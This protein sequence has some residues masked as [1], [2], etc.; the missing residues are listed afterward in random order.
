MGRKSKLLLFA[1]LVLAFLAV[2]K[3]AVRAATFTDGIVLVTSSPFDSGWPA[4]HVVVPGVGTGDYEATATVRVWRD[5]ESWAA[6]TGSGPRGV[7]VG[8]ACKANPRCAGKSVNEWYGGTSFAADPYDFQTKSFRFT[9][10]TAATGEQH[11]YGFMFSVNDGAEAELTS[12][13]LKKK[14]S[15]G[16]YTQSIAV[17]NFN[18][19]SYAA[20]GVAKEI[21]TRWSSPWGWWGRGWVAN[22]NHGTAGDKQAT[23]V[24]VFRSSSR[25][26]TGYDRFHSEGITLTPGKR[27]ILKSRMWPYMVYGD[28]VD[29]NKVQVALA[30]AATTCGKRAD[31]TNI[32][33]NDWMGSINVTARTSGFT[34]FVSTAIQIPATATA[35]TWDV[36]IF[37]NDGSQVYF[38]SLLLYEEG[39]PTPLLNSDPYFDQ[40]QPQTVNTNF[41]TDWAVSQYYG[42]AGETVAPWPRPL[43]W[44]LNSRIV[45][46]TGRSLAKNVHVFHA[47]WPPN[48]LTWAYDTGSRTTFTAATTRAV[49]I[50]S[51]DGSNNVYLGVEA[52]HT[53]TKDLWPSGTTQAYAELKPKGN[54]PHAAM[55]FARYFNPYTYMVQWTRSL[56]QGTYTVDFEPQPEHM[57]IIC[58]APSPTPTKTP[59]PTPTKTPTP[60]LVPTAACGLKTKGD[61]NCDNLINEADYTIWKCQFKGGTSCGQPNNAA[62]FDL[63]G[64][65]TVNDFEIWRRFSSTVNVTPTNSPTPTRTPT[66][67]P[68]KTPTPTPTAAPGTSYYKVFLTSATYTGALGGLTGADQKCQTLANNAGLTGTY[69]AWLTDNNNNAKDRIQPAAAKPYRLVDGTTVIA[70]SLA[71]LI[72]GTIANPI[73]KTEAGTVVSRTVPYVWTGT[74]PGGTKTVD[75]QGSTANC[76]NWTIGTNAVNGGIGDFSKTTRNWTDPPVWTVCNSQYSLYCFQTADTRPGCTTSTDCATGETCSEGQCVTTDS[77]RIAGLKQQMSQ[78]ESVAVSNISLVYSTAYNWPDG[79]IGCATAGTMCTQVITPG[80]KTVLKA[81]HPTQ[82]GN[83]IYKQYNTASN[84]T[85]GCTPAV[86]GKATASCNYTCPSNTSCT[87]SCPNGFAKDLYGCTACQCLPGGSAVM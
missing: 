6:G 18:L 58:P 39:K 52:N 12:I 41:P 53:I 7:S 87:L 13:S 86:G 22:I 5:S 75:S 84:N 71:D 72:D 81:L 77:P 68:S 34:D 24:L 59:T 70:N 54:P 44:T 61:A 27:Y 42:V 62:D 36:R 46:P 35:S 74:A 14:D 83:C 57:D 66:P 69:K 79:C 80:Y 40:H 19:N 2:P 28:G 67:T 73:N 47:K 56:P 26:K 78:E 64:G 76:T 21:T 60:T 11:V 23:N 16:N 32:N 31:G 82:A 4:A 30:C 8:F 65:I 48:P 63:S 37:V 49:T 45:C 50:T 43:T 55:T 29:G 33:V 3:D 85:T 20:S 51:T 38:D 17:P 15:S 1:V 25:N 10:P 9:I